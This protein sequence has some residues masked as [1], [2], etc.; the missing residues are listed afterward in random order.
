MFVRE[1]TLFTSNVYLLLITEVYRGPSCDLVMNVIT[2]HLWA[3]I[4]DYLEACERMCTKIVVNKGER[5]DRKT[6][7]TQV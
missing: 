5:L 7:K 2:I 4:L 6:V 3:E 1:M